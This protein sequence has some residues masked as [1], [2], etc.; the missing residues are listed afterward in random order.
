MI[1]V[2]LPPE[3]TP[4]PLEE[5]RYLVPGGAKSRQTL[6]RWCMTGIGGVRLEHLQVGRETFTSQ[7]A[8]RRFFARVTTASE[9]RRR[10]A[11]R[12]EEE[13]AQDVEKAL[14][15]LESKGF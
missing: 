4:I 12:S 6:W 14:K 10:R 7:E 2:V 3:E 8:L 13:R 1:T 15:E 9:A 5:A 11:T